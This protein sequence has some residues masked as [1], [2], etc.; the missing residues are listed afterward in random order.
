MPSLPQHRNGLSSVYSDLLSAADDGQVFVLCLL[1]LTASF[2]TVDHDLLLHWLECLFG[3][4]GVVLLWFR[5]CMRGRS[6][7]VLYCGSFHVI[8]GVHHSPARFCPRS[9][10]WLFLIYCWPWRRYREAWCDVACACRQ[11]IAVSALSSWWYGIIWE[12]SKRLNWSALRLEDSSWTL[13]RTELLWAGSGHSCPLLGDYSLALQ[14]AVDTV[15]SSNDARVLGVT[16]TSDLT[17][18]HGYVRLR[19][20]WPVFIGNCDMSGD[21]WIQRKRRH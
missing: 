10:R 1:D 21:R 16:L 11:H 8:H 17:N 12:L 4:H 6:F 5:S 18:D 9:S 20:A 13:D 7:R 2:N 15:A 19:S 3:L 14:F